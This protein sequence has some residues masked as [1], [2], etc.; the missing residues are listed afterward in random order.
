[1]TPYR[2]EDWA[3]A[4]ALLRRIIR[5][6]SRTSPGQIWVMLRLAAPCD[7]T[8]E[9]LAAELGVCRETVNVWLDHLRRAGLITIK[10]KG[11]S[12]GAGAVRQLTPAGIEFLTG[13]RG[14][15]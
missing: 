15:G 5:K 13:R 10:R 1:M 3:C 6:R 8:V 4:A 12:P 11:R 14:Q 2:A 9:C 7:L